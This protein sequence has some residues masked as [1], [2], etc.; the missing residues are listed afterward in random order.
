M[1]RVMIRKHVPLVLAALIFGCGGLQPNVPDEVDRTPDAAFFDDGDAG[2]DVVDAGDDS[3]A[4]VILPEDP[5]SGVPDS[6]VIEEVDS[7]VVPDAGAPDSGTFDAGSPDAGVADAGTPVPTTAL[8]RPNNPMPC[9]DPAVVSE[10][11]AN[12]LFYV[13]CT[14]MSHVW[15][16]ADW[17]H[18]SDVRS[19]VTFTLTGMSAN[20]KTLGAWWAPGIV[21]SPALNQY[22]M[23]VSVPDAQATN[24]S[25]GWDSRSLAV[26]TSTSPAG[27]WTFRAIA[28]DAAVGEHYI[29]PFLFIDHDGSRYVYWK[30]YGGG[31][32]SSIM[33][34]SVNAAWT[35]VNSASQMEV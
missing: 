6:G 20:G 19:T 28:L 7:G 21:Y 16:T 27:P 34:A 14:S 4:S 17:V 33:G 10:G 13:Y 32:S 3:D 24:T 23:W 18:F 5:D 35:A 30:Q 15:K 1:A 2:Q 11:G 8:L 31:L 9:A 29:D 12:Q 25:T 26:L 22:V